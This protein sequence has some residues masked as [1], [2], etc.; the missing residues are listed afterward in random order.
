M[1]SEKKQ[2]KG[3]NRDEMVGQDC[4]KNNIKSN[5]NKKSY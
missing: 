1:K 2:I 5:I 3:E 4:A